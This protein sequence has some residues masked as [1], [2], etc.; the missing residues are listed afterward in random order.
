M[1][2]FFHFKAL[3]NHEFDNGV[4]GLAP[5][6]KNVSFPVLSA[7]IDSSN[8]PVIDG[9]FDASWMT[10]INGQ[11]IGVVGYTMKETPDLVSRGQIFY[12]K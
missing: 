1:H 4:Q 11:T 10:V 3:G 5:F 12:F 2:F 9:L 6:L 8:E 7:N